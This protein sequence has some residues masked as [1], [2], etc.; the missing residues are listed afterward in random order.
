MK[1]LKI[2]NKKNKKE[3]ELKGHVPGE[4]MYTHA[5]SSASAQHSGFGFGRVAAL[6]DTAKT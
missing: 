3:E 6:E 4:R 1:Q 2:K 5:A